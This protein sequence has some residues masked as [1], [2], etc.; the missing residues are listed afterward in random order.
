MSRSINWGLV[1]LSG[2]ILAIAALLIGLLWP[3]MSITDDDALPSG[4]VDDVETSCWTVKVDGDDSGNRV[5][6]VGLNGS[7]QE[8]ES[9][10]LKAAKHDP[11]AL[12]GLYNMSPLVQ[13][14]RLTEV[15]VAANGCYT[16]TGK[17]AWYALVKQMNDA[18][19]TNGTAPGKGCNT[20]VVNN[21]VVVKCEMILGDREATKIVWGDGSVTWILHRCGNPMTENP[22]PDNPEP[23]P[24]DCHDR[25]DC[26][27]PETC[28]DR[29]DCPTPTPTCEE[30]GNCPPPK[31][32]TGQVRY[33]DRC[34][35]AADQ[36]DEDES[37]GNDS[38][39]KQDVNENHQDPTDG[40]SEEEPP[41]PDREQGD[42]NGGSGD[43]GV[44]TPTVPDDNSDSGQTS[45]PT[46]T[47]APGVCTEPEAWM[48]E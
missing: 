29:G 17:Q 22:P 1:A 24:K 14:G 25:G 16:A 10:L 37:G 44:A 31:C 39:T 26:P 15:D 13:K 27:K 4:S 21:K 36:N 7:V 42:P 2:A 43:G 35:K 33:E 23:E 8:V 48:C 40:A 3:V 18:E 9:Q 34:V 47:P 20:Y 12:V 6:K 28:E 32:P 46:P 45:S 11:S 41:P 30:L 19:K 38:P 5:I